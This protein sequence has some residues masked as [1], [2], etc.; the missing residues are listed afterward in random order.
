MGD[1]N[2]LVR[3]VIF[4]AALGAAISLLDRETREKT[5]NQVKDCSKR[6]WHYSKNPSE[7]ID[8]ISHK[9]SAT[10]HKLEEVTDDIAFIVEKV[11]EIKESGDK[12]LSSCNAAEGKDDL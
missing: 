11:N 2:K 5:V 8:N 9:V 7:I 10:R 6:V 4:G 3:G 12:L 1:N